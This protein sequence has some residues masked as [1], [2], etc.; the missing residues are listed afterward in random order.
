MTFDEVKAAV[1]SL[2]DQ[3]KLRVVT[4]LLP[5]IWQKIVC[6]DACLEFLRKMVDEAAVAKYKDEHMDSI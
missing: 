4:E 1:M 2:D 3:G 5:A 6:D